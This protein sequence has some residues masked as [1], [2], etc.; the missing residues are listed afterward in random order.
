[1]AYMRASSLSS[2]DGCTS[3]ESL[4][5]A[6]LAVAVPSSGASRG[7][8]QRSSSSRGDGVDGGAGPKPTRGEGR[9]FALICTLSDSS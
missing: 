2:G 8:Y 5:E 6:A 1:M 7:A 4:G 3:R 9:R